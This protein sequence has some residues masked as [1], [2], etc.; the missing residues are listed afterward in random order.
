MKSASF[1]LFAA[2]GLVTLT[3]CE[4]YLLQNPHAPPAVQSVSSQAPS[5]AG[6]M[7]PLCSEDLPNNPCQI[8]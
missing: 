1:A 2:L 4:E 8:R 7:E 5:T 6:R 3:G